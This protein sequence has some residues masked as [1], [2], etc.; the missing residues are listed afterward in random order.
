MVRGDGG[1]WVLVRAGEGCWELVRWCGL[2]RAGGGWCLLVAP[3]ATETIASDDERPEYQH[4]GTQQSDEA[5]VEISA[6]GVVGV[7]S[8]RLPADRRVL[9]SGGPFPDLHTH[10]HTPS[11]NSDSHTFPSTVG[12]NRGGVARVYSAPLFSPGVSESQKPQQAGRTKWQN[13]ET[14]QISRANRRGR[15]ESILGGC[16]RRESSTRE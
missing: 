7:E 5:P 16:L 12:T 1:V 6:C 3:T 9:G 4:C 2:L 8:V 11:H 13:P 10:S 15:R 14:Q